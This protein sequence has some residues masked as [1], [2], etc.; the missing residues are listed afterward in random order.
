[1]NESLEAA[2]NFKQTLAVAAL[3]G[4]ALVSQSTL[5]NPMTVTVTYAGSANFGFGS[6]GYDSGSVAPNPNS[7]SGLVGVGIGG[8][9]F[10]TANLG[11]NFSETGQFNA[12]CVDI[13]HWMSGGTVNY[14]V[15]TG[16]DLA[17]V[18][19]A[20][21]PNGPSGQTRVDQLIRLANEIYYTVDTRDESAA[22]QLAVWEIAYGTPG[23]NGVYQINSSESGFRV[24]TNTLNSSFGR[25]AN[26]WLSELNTASTELDPGVWTLTYLNDGAGNYTQDV[27]V[28]TDPLPTVPEPATMALLGLGLGGLGFIRRKKA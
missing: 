20:L 14:N 7:A 13:Y 25:L 9:S 22:F 1:M 10:T 27:I 2:M 21:R 23:S 5:A 17:S 8:D 11:Y 16:S 19:Q 15:G 26:T 12:W 6:V 28:F 18:L 4:A 3:M 24:D